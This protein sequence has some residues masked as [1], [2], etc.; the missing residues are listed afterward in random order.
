MSL[1][2]GV[3]ERHASIREVSHRL[4][5][6]QTVQADVRVSY[7]NPGQVGLGGVHALSHLVPYP[8]LTAREAVN[9]TQGRSNAFATTGEVRELGGPGENELVHAT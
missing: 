3:V 8:R 5:F 7:P 6:L 9:R 2:A 4:A 1:G